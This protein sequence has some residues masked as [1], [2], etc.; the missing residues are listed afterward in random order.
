VGTALIRQGDRL[1]KLLS[2]LPESHD[3]AARL[4]RQ[5]GSEAVWEEA[6]AY[7]LR[8]LLAH[9]LPSV[10]SLSPE[11]RDVAAFQAARVARATTTLTRALAR[12]GV[13]AVVL[14]GAPLAVRLYPAPWMR[15][16]VDVDLLVH[17]R[18]LTQA[19]RAL[20]R[21][22]YILAKGLP[23]S[24]DRFTHHLTFA[25]RGR[26]EVELHFSVSAL[27]QS[28]FDCDGTFARA[29]RHRLLGEEVLALGAADEVVALAVHAASHGFDGVKWL[30][31]LK[32]LLRRELPPWNEVIAYARA[33]RVAV[34]TGMAL[35]ET[36]SRMGGDV[37]SWVLEEFGAGA[38]RT[39]SVELLRRHAKPTVYV[40]ALE[41]LLAD[42]LSRT[43]A[44]RLS[45]PVLERAARALGLGERLHALWRHPQTVEGS[46]GM[47]PDRPKGNHE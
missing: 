24:P 22:G 44:V 15:P 26:V 17:P 46:D 41:V 7:G 16:S 37:P 5:L 12:E 30:F 19:T 13:R 9:Y 39:A 42:R 18:D 40:W 27:F 10:F 4:L 31:D 47:F 11:E 1:E 33:A 21:E 23:D 3:R 8:P 35:A 36:R 43:W 14:K 20:E 32:L 45:A 2:E 29:T 38:A 6:K 25:A 34:A 28:R